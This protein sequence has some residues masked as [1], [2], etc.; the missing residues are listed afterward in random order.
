M[1]KQKQSTEDFAKRLKGLSDFAFIV[2]SEFLK[3]GKAIND[4][5]YRVYIAKGAIYGANQKGYH[6]WLKSFTVDN[7][8]LAPTRG[9]DD[10][11]S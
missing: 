11:K 2:S 10:R 9:T 6:E 3:L 1:N 4:A 8:S 5:F 7:Q